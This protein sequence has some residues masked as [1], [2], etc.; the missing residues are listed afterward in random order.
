[1]LVVCFSSSK[2]N[3]CAGTPQNN[4]CI[5]IRNVA[6]TFL[7]LSPC[8]EEKPY[9]RFLSEKKSCRKIKSLSFHLCREN[10]RNESSGIREY[11]QCD[12]HVLVK[13]QFCQQNLSDQTIFFNQFIK[14]VPCET[15]RLLLQVVKL[16]V[17]H[18]NQIL[19]FHCFTSVRTTT[20]SAQSVYEPAPGTTC[21]CR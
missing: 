7:L 13:Y 19:Q 2:E 5:R 15:H 20:R 17:Y 11:Q 14:T 6:P 8:C 12:P 4:T 16:S 10:A 3:F 21:I 1:M 9:I 18:T